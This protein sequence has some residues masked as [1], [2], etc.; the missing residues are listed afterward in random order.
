MTIYETLKM[1]ERP[2]PCGAGTMRVT[3][4]E[5]DHAWRSSSVSWD[6]ELDCEKC[7]ERYAVIEQG[8]RYVLVERVH[9]D[10]RGRHKDE[11][12]RIRAQIEASG[13]MAA[14]RRA[15]AERLAALPS[16]AA[17]HRLASSARAASGGDAWFKGELS[18]GPEQYAERHITAYNAEHAA[19]ALG[20]DLGELAGLFDGWRR[21]REL[22]DAKLPTIGEPLYELPPMAWYRP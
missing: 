19:A 2:C 6:G 21:E 4:T 11:V 20:I 14:V 18:R 8:N 13:S 16:R 5:P 22:A 1:A 12:D 15:F 3:R 17:K 7:K 10:E 9:L